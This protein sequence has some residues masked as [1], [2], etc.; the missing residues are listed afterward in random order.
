MLKVFSFFYNIARRPSIWYAFKLWFL[1][2]ICQAQIVEIIHQSLG[3]S[4][5]WHVDKILYMSKG[6]GQ[7]K[8]RQDHSSLRMFTCRRI[9]C[10]MNPFVSFGFNG[11]A[12]G[13]EFNCKEKYAIKVVETK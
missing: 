9:H 1:K 12:D 10:C 5:R 7:W 2:I 6:Y 4:Y 13:L 3:R 8:E 11:H